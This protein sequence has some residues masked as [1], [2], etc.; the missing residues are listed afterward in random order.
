MQKK[1]GAYFQALVL[2]SH[3]WLLFL[4]SHFCLFVSSAFFLV[5]FSFQAEEKKE[6]HKERKK[7]IQRREGDYLSFFNFA[8][9]IKGSSCFFLSTFLQH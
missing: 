4:A 1:E 6:E 2:P 9:E 8:F 7:K 3:F 5:S